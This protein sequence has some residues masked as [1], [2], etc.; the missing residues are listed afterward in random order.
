MATKMK[1]R[2]DDPNE[3]PFVIENDDDDKEDKKRAKESDDE[4]DGSSYYIDDDDDD[5]DDDDDSDGDGEG[6]RKNRRDRKRERGRRLG[7]VDDSS[8]VIR[9]LSERLARAEGALSRGFPQQEKKEEGPDPIDTEIAK[10]GKALD[11]ILELYNT[12]LVSKTA[13]PE[14]IAEWQKDAKELEDELDELKYQRRVKKSQPKESPNTSMKEHIMRLHPDIYAPGN[15]RIQAWARAKLT[16]RVSE[17]APENLNTLNEVME[18]ARSTFG[19]P[20]R[21]QAKSSA[22][23]AMRSRLAGIPRSSG[24]AA[25]SEPKRKKL[26]VHDMRMA[27]SRFHYIKDKDKRYRHYY[28]E[29]I[30]K[31]EKD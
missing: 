8:E 7:H 6:G 31:P 9:E 28:K 27:D 14:K 15:Q 10:K 5:E 30:R 13:T 3:D 18:E 16:L 4:E 2:E 25:S 11:R 23:P 24:A 1:N 21:S 12:A 22:T 17:G 19:L 26:S 20:S 29:V